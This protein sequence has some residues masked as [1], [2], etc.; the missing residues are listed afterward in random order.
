MR[1]RRHATQPRRHGRLRVLLAIRNYRLYFIGQNISV[2]GNWMLNVALGWYVLEET[3][4]GTALGLITGLRFLPILLFGLWG[5]LLSDRVSKH[6]ILVITNFCVIVASGCFS[7]LL[8]LDRASVE[9]AA[10]LAFVLGCI[11]AIQQ[12]AQNAFVVEMVSEDHL[13]NAIAL[14]ATT[15]NTARIVGPSIAGVLL[16]TS[17][18]A[19]CFALNA[20]SS[21]MIVWTLLAMRK[22]ELLPSDPILRS[23]GQLLA[24]LHYIAKD[25]EILIPLL[26]TAVAGTLAWEYQ[27]SLPLM[28]TDVFEA[29]ASAYAA[30]LSALGLGAIIGGVWLASRSTFT[31]R[32]LTWSSLGWGVTMVVAA[33]MPTL[34]SALLVFLFVGYGA[35]AFN[36]R[37]KTMIQMASEPQYR[38]RVMGM[39]LLAWQGTTVLGAPLIGWLGDTVGGRWALG[40]GGLGMILTG[41]LTYRRRPVMRAALPV[42]RPSSGSPSANTA[43]LLNDA[44]LE[45]I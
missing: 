9:A 27:V 19:S 31:A 18:P 33:I 28:A 38:G 34:Y 2:A 40:A 10:V 16:A 1:F 22:S 26:A 7:V 35:T 37:S 24:G 36:A 6:R 15:G 21:I 41:L 42:P 43:D 13:P 11:S 3:G 5:G 17:G 29:G 39:W 45:G 32:S 14:N 44:R 12:P 4:N 8:S 23:R 25:R 20:V 30:M